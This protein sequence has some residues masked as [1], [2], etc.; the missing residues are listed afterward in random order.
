MAEQWIA[1]RPN[2]GTAGQKD[3]QI[4]SRYTYT[5]RLERSGTVKVASRS[6]PKTYRNIAVKQ[7]GVGLRYAL[8]NN[9][10]ELPSNGGTARFS[11]NTNT[12]YFGVK[13]A[14]GIFMP[15]R[16]FKLYINDTLVTPVSVNNALF[17]LPEDVGATEW[18]TM[19]IDFTLAANN[20]SADRISTM[21]ILIY[22]TP[23]TLSLTETL[24][25]TTRTK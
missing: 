18:Y 12:F 14:S 4:K 13:S 9:E 16:A 7:S 15:A 8:V 24:T 11:C 10:V 20:E 19:D 25:V 23:Y 21:L 2:S 22:E 3:L 5:G 17:R 6:D 1:F